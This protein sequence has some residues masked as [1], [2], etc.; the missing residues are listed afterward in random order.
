P[1]SAAARKRDIE[2]ASRCAGGMECERGMSGKLG[3]L[4]FGEDQQELFLGREF[5]HRARNLS[6]R[7]A[8][9]IDDEVRKIVTEQYQRAKAL[10]VDNKQALDRIAAA[11]LEW[12]T[13][14]GADVEALL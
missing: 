12:E 8:I 10:L 11:L 1:G 4:A 9:D 3:P 14:D 7:T 6:E 5:G 13:L 2:Q